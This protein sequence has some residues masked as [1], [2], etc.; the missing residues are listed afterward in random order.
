MGKHVLS[1]AAAVAGLSLLTGPVRL[2]AT[3][4][5]KS[6]ADV[7][8]VFQA[9][10]PTLAS[11]QPMVDAFRKALGGANNGNSTG[12]ISTGWREID[13]DGGGSTGPSAVPT[14]FDGFLGNRG[15]RLTTTGTGFVQASTLG[16]ATTFNNPAYSNIFQPFSQER[17][18]SPIGSN[19][20]IGQFF[21]PG[22]GELPAITTGF[23]AV[24]SDVDRS[25]HTWISF[26]GVQGD[27]L[28]SDI[29][30][31]S[32]GDAGLSFLG[33]VFPD[34]RIA[35]V[36]ITT[37]KHAPGPHDSSK[38]DVVMMDDFV[39]G[40]PQPVHYSEVV[41]TFEVLGKH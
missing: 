2:F 33:V 20:T 17:L 35:S 19:V 38:R 41:Y 29:V 34:P 9:S 7:D 6:A 3:L 13:W 39:F 15:L 21:V 40:E 30:P 5:A 27:L 36:R 12:P 31:G 8:I 24:F 32:G 37:G 28:F 16:M 25:R 18:F 22:G 26:F 10:G 11:I 1:L 4:D 23:G 14:P